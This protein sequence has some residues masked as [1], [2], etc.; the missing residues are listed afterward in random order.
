MTVIAHQ[1]RPSRTELGRCL[2]ES[3]ALSSDWAPAFAAVDRAAFLPPVMWPFIPTDRRQSGD[4][5]AAR[6]VTVDR[7]TD[8][9]AWY[10]YAD[11]D[12]SVV[13]QWDDGDHRGDHP[14]TVPTSSSSQPSVVFRLLAA[15]DP[16]AGMRVLDAGTGTGETAAL[17]AHRCGAANVT[18]ID[19]DP[20]VSAAARERLCTLGLYA[21]AVTGDALAG[22]PDR[23]LYD[24]LL[25]T[26]GVRSI[27]RAWVEQ[28]RPGGVIV[29]PY[30]THYSSRDAAARLT[31]HADGTASGPF[32]TAVEFMKA[33]SHRTVWPDAEKYV[34]QWPGSTGTAVQPDQ[35]AEAHHAI[36]LA[37]PHVAHTTHTEPDGA[38]AAWW[39]S[40]TD[41]SWAAVR[42]PEEYGPGIVYQHGPRH[43]WDAV[44]AACGWWEAQ[45]SP[46]LDRFGLTVGPDGETPWLDDPGNLLPGTRWR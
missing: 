34:K 24:R 43:L 8:P 32:V 20:A 14:G 9:A 35:L 19:V 22:Y 42:W 46:A 39:Y 28:V 11:S 21:E 2:M 3:G 12:L 16:D 45:G 44:E 13:T 29:A 4:V 10:G 5:L 31:V 41:H 38:P 36:S 30:G 33:R 27:P 37:V 25:C 26:F 1:E 6:A 15:L 40:L 7:R 23:A 18:T 17:L